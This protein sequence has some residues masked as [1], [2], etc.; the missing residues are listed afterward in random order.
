MARE[1]V[2]LV[3]IIQNKRR[4]YIYISYCFSLIIHQMHLQFLL[5]YLLDKILNLDCSIN[6][7]NSCYDILIFLLITQELAQIHLGLAKLMES[8]D[9]IYSL[10]MTQLVLYSHH[11]RQVTLM[12]QLL[13]VVLVHQLQEQQ[14]VIKHLLQKP[15]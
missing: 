12:F 9:L 4:E 1:L 10:Q 7:K 3:V 11:S 8:L 14:R 5:L 6:S 13:P 2:V 15:V